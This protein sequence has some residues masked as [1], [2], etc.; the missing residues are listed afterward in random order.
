[1]AGDI[2][3]DTGQS[4]ATVERHLGMAGGRGRDGGAGAGRRDRDPPAP[5]GCI[6][7][8]VN[9]AI[10]YIVAGALVGLALLAIIAL[11]IY[12]HQRDEPQD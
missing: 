5:W 12:Q 7:E 9:A 4:P 2:A 10:L 8:Q 6:T 11:L 3:R 1:V